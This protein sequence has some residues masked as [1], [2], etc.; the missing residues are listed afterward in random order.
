MKAKII[1]FAGFFFIQF[2]ILLAQTPISYQGLVLWLRADTGVVMSGNNVT[3]WDDVSGNLNHGFPNASLPFISSVSAINGKSAV[4]FN[5]CRLALTTNPIYNLN[6][7]T[8]LFVAKL[9]PTQ[10][11][12]YFYDFNAANN[13]CLSTVA[14]GIGESGQAV[15]VPLDSSAYFIYTKQYDT[16][17]TPNTT[18]FFNTINQNLGYNYPRAN[19]SGSKWIGAS[20]SGDFT[21]QGYIAEFIIYNRK[22]NPT[23][24]AGVHNYLLGHYSQANVNLGPDLNLNSFCSQTLHAGTGYKKYLWSTGDSIDSITVSAPGTYWVNTINAFDVPS[25]DTIVISYPSVAQINDTILCAGATFTWNTGLSK[26]DYTFEW[27]DLSTDSLYI[28]SQPGPHFAKITDAFNCSFYTDTIL[29]EYDNFNTYRSYPSDTVFCSG[30]SLAPLQ[31]P[32]S[33]S[34]YTWNNNSQ[35]PTI[36]VNQPTGFYTYWVDLIDSLGCPKR[37]SIIVEINGV[38]P[39]PLF[40]FDSLVCYGDPTH[41]TDF[42][43]PPSGDTIVSWLWNFDDSTSV[44]NIDSTQNPTH[45][46]SAAGVYQAKLKITTVA[47]CSAVLTKEVHINPIPLANFVK[48]NLNACENNETFF[49][50]TSQTFGS[51]VLSYTWD[52][53]DPGSGTNNSSSLKNPKHVYSAAGTYQVSLTVLTVFGC[54]DSINKTIQVIQAPQA[55]FSSAVTCEGYPVAMQDNSFL[56]FPRTV[57]NN[58]W[59]F[60]DNSPLIV[61]SFPNLISAVTHSFLNPV[62]THLITYKITD[63]KGCKDSIAKVVQV[64]SKPLANFSY[65]KNCLNGFTEF[66]DKSMQSTSLGVDSL[67]SWNWKFDNAGTSS[68]KNPTYK[69]TSIGAH[70]V[71]LIVRT[72]QGCADTIVKTVLISP[73]PIASF[74]QSA[75]VGDPPLPI[76]FIN[77]STEGVIGFS[78]NFGDG[79]AL[80]QIENPT[81]IFTDTGTFVI[82]LTVTDTSGCTA[83][84]VHSL[85]VKTASVDIAVLAVRTSLDEE[86]YLHVS[87]DIQNQGTRKIYKVDLYNFINGQAPSKE[88]LTDTLEIQE[89]ITYNFIGL[90]RISD[91]NASNFVCVEAIKPNGVDDYFPWNN[92]MCISF[93]DDAFIFANPFPN[94]VVEELMVPFILPADGQVEIKIYDGLGK[95]VLDNGKQNFSKGLNQTVLKTNFLP[96]GV[97][98]VRVFYKDKSEVKRFIKLGNTKN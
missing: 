20:P 17:S 32:N 40:T 52:F 23:E 7:Y 93:I 11:A 98:A 26:A 18:F 77:T 6:D 71:R 97:Y 10:G 83:N 37:D 68:L 35:F 1:L 70:T 81:H 30:N 39:S 85:F 4:Y 73:L 42:S 31:F 5:D 64:V 12:C 79:S 90:H 38:A 69:F 33:I 41:F 58:S 67:F 25:S 50:N 22:L 89:S 29:I 36:Q 2:G 21:K 76:D 59:N 13:H 75:T 9:N 28:I 80:S 24:L 48:T 95:V 87:A 92:E 55:N 66:T 54:S 94:P 43:F 72:L 74:S 61:S 56:P 96:C 34:S 8:I 44:S 47:G 51:P 45:L 49:S 19:F 62:G 91:S 27:Q 15:K 82:R 53:G 14:Q 57:L 78:W 88:I 60:N 46:Y 63:S 3:E 16:L 86:N 84:A 65:T